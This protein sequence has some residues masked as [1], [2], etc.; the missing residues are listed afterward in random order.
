MPKPIYQPDDIDLQRFPKTKDTNLRAWNAADEYLIQSAKEKITSEIDSILIINDQFGALTCAFSNYNTLVWTDSFLSATAIRANLHNLNHS[1]KKKFQLP[2]LN[3]VNQ[4]DLCIPPDRFFDLVLIRIPKHNSLLDFQLRSILPHINQ[5]TL[6]ISAGM[7]KQIHK[8]N[9][10][11]F[12]SIIG[13]TNTSLAKKK[14]RLVH[15]Q[16]SNAKTN[17]K[18]SDL[19]TDCLK[20]F[21]LEKQN[22]KIHGYPGVFSRKSLDLG[23]CVLVEYLP[24]TKS[25]DK[26]LDLG[27]GTG[28]LGTLA[29]KLNPTLEVTFTDESWLA[30]ESA[31]KTFEHNICGKAVFEV[32]NVLDGLP[33]IYYDY[34]LCNPPF[35]QQNVQ[36]LAIANKMFK[37]SAEKLI[38]AGDLRVVANRHLNYRNMLD[39]YFEK[40]D[41]LSKDSKFIVWRAQ[42]PKHSAIDK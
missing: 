41:I 20:T 27:C 39:R 29:A 34:I 17:S 7:T 1:K 31:R 22:L 13:N 2:S 9:L 15:S 32:N 14:A 8:S 28:V 11:L 38:E 33:D 30:I 6:I 35:H 5:D 19:E 4:C 12:E 42:R 37:D 40:V 25:N 16:Y 23:T 10:N 26:L 24:Q 18:N 3:L 21:I 36:T